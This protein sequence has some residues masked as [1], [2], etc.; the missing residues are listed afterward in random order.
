MILSRYSSKIMLLAALP[1][2]L[3][4]FLL[5]LV[6]HHQ[7]NQ[8]SDATSERSGVLLEQVYAEQL[9]NL[10]GELAEKIA[11]DFQAVINELV[12]LAVAAQK[13]IDH[14]AQQASIQT[15]IPSPP[16]LVYDPVKNWSY[17]H[18]AEDNIGVSI[19][20]EQH[21]ADADLTEAAKLYLQQMQPVNSVLSVL[22]QSPVKKGW[23]Y[24]IGPKQAPIFILYPAANIAE[25]FDQKY[26]GYNVH[27]WWDFFAPQAIE[28]WQ[29]WL[30]QPARLQ[31]PPLQQVVW[32]PV[33]DDGAGTGEMVTFW[34]PLWTADRRDNYGTA[35]VDFNLHTTIELLQH[36][37]IGSSGFAFLMKNNG[38]AFGL[39][40]QRI[41]QL[42]LSESVEVQSGITLVSHNVMQSEN[43]ALA[44]IAQTFDRAD[45]SKHYRFV[46]AEGTPYLLSFKK[47]MD[48]QMWQPGAAQTL[49][50]QT[51]Y[52]AA[53]MPETD[54]AVTR[55]AITDH[56][57]ELNDDTF[58]FLVVFALMFALISALVG[59]VFAW[60]TT[61]QIRKLTQGLQSVAKQDYASQIEVVSEDELGALAQTFNQMLAEVERAH[62]ELAHYAEDLET[63]VSE[64][65]ASL[66]LAKQ[67]AQAA[68]EDHLQLMR[69]L[70]HEVRSPLAAISNCTAV[71]QKAHDNAS[72]TIESP[73][74][75]D[76]MLQRIH[77]S[78]KRLKRFMDGL[79]AEDRFNHLAE[80]QAQ[81]VDIC[82]SIQQ[83]IDNLQQTYPLANIDYQHQG[84]ERVWLKDPVLF[85]VMLTN[86]LDNAIKYS[87][88]SS[89]VSLAVEVADSGALSLLVADRGMG[90]E[91]AMMAQIFK[92]YIRG[93]QAEHITGTGMGLY[94]VKRIVSRFGGDISLAEREGGGVIVR[95]S[96]PAYQQEISHESD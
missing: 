70:S 78:I 27:N 38:D 63:K 83:L 85:E 87:P 12:V 64:R 10:S 62:C 40:E 7:L 3:F 16:G 80:Q 53:L 71:I 25:L 5:A 73:G 26:P 69:M 52:L 33:Y 91:P 30:L 60:R 21:L 65:T 93:K 32:T 31:V 44:E 11:L 39:S 79:T 18:Y 28:Q 15:S 36:Q 74:L 81:Q 19:F 29:A 20:G 84:S 58:D 66:E 2:L 96:L 50:N 82:H 92:K 9:D 13:Q 61:L 46:D 56:I 6:V 67:E 23:M 54:I 89:L 94:L 88:N 37:R 42:Q 14:F 22:G 41:A 8:F 43:A 57:S 90:I 68:L 17:L 86:L 95:V 77:Y 72:Q 45:L 4:S 75:V 35:G 1:I 48:Y 76:D 51:F 24:L 49:T 59:G 55:Q 47:V 34:L